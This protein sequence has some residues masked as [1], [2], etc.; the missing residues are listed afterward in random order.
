MIRRQ[1]YVVGKEAQRSD[2]LDE[3]GF[4]K[5][6]FDDREQVRSAACNKLKA[7]HTN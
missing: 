3:K 6:T 5:E 7:F 1:E 2:Y 4:K